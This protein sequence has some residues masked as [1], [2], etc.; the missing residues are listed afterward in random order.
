MSWL[1]SDIPKEVRVDDLVIRQFVGKDAAEFAEAVTESLPALLHWMPW[2]KLEPQT[3]AQR[4]ELIRS[5]Q[6]DWT[7]KRD[8]PMGIFRD[9]K[10]VGSSGL[11]VRHGVGQ[12]EI[13][14]WVRTSCTGQG[15][16][17]R[18]AHALTDAAFSIDEVNEVLIA[19]DIAN[20][21]SQSVPERLGYSLEKEYTTDPKAISETGRMRLWSMKKTVWIVR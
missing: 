21:R 18:A 17:T 11:H 1:I 3:M 10:I 15:I 7:D 19:H 9:G 8:F 2:A 16:A 4:E 6:I 5:W 20:V 13:G 14:Y 12:L